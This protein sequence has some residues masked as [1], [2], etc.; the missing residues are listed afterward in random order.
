V[1]V[2]RMVISS[3]RMCE[4]LLPFMVAFVALAGL[5][6]RLSLATSILGQRPADIVALVESAFVVAPDVPLVT[7]GIDK[8][9]LYSFAARW[10][11]RTLGLLSCSW[12]CHDFYSSHRNWDFCPDASNRRAEE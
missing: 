1:F 11:P 7:A 12:L 8:F 4:R 3:K 9:P 2:F 10:R 5:G 6:N